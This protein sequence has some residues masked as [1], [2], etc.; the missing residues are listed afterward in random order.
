MRL[1]EAASGGPAAE[2]HGGR[3]PPRPT[4][5]V[6]RMNTAKNFVD[7]LQQPWSSK[8]S[9]ELLIGHTSVTKAH[10]SLLFHIWELGF[11]HLLCLGP[12]VRNCGGYNTEASLWQSPSM[13]SIGRAQPTRHPMHSI[14]YGARNSGRQCFIWE[15]ILAYLLKQVKSVTLKLCYSSESTKKL[16]KILMPRP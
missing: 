12:C 4:A 8:W 11:E 6:C 1:H 7:H 9:P 15:Y 2:A 10:T 3:G 14:S 13:D 16:L 5:D